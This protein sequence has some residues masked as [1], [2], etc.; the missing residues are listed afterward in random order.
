VPAAAWVLVA[1]SF[2]V[3]AALQGVRAKVVALAPWAGLVIDVAA[4]WTIVALV[5][6][7]S[8]AWVTGTDPTMIPASALGVPVLGVFLT[9]FV[10]TFVK[11]LFDQYTI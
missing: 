10:C 2:V 7:F 11:A 6:V 8:P 9:W 4:V 5:S 3:L 1:T